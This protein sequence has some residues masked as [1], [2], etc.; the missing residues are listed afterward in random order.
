MLF[1][2]SMYNVNEK[3]VQ[4]YRQAALGFPS[5]VSKRPGRSSTF[6]SS[7]AEEGALSD[8]DQS[9]PK[10]SACSLT[11]GSCSAHRRRPELVGLLR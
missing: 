4:K 1:T 6:P 10:Y 9:S 11:K 5:M 7:G 3:Q 8:V 2:T